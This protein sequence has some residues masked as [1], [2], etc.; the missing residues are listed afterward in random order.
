MMSYFTCRYKYFFWSS[1]G[2]RRTCLR[3][4]WEKL[5]SIFFFHLLH[6]FWG[7]AVFYRDF[8]LPEEQIIARVRII[9]YSF[10]VNLMYLIE[11]FTFHAFHVKRILGR[12]KFG[13]EELYFSFKKSFEGTHLKWEP[14]HPYLVTTTH[15][16]FV[17]EKFNRMWKPYF[18]FFYKKLP[19][20]PIWKK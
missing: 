13:S 11:F 6:I 17:T 9:F 1:A 2:M 18:H 4:K 16:Y 15:L 14:T 19:T 5:I 7:P 20:P 12:L 10:F 3:E 8:T